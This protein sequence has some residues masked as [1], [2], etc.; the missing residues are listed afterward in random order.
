MWRDTGQRWELKEAA[1]ASEEL[2]RRQELTR[3]R[4]AGGEH[5]GIC[6]WLAR[7]WEQPGSSCAS[8][9]PGG[10]LRHQEKAPVSWHRAA[11]TQM[12]APGRR[13]V[14]LSRG[15]IHQGGRWHRGRGDTGQR[16]HPSP[17]QGRCTSCLLDTKWRISRVQSP[18]CLDQTEKYSPGVCFWSGWS[19]NFHFKRVLCLY[20][21]IALGHW[22]WKKCLVSYKSILLQRLSRT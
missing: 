6:T 21:S 11:W 13:S 9:T 17:Q 12:P 3:T 15:N 20:Y 16:L 10:M 5:L 2:L 8:F 14:L 7:R 4:G 19:K 22:M 18:P 1:G